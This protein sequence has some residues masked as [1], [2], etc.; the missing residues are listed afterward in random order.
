MAR[1]YSGKILKKK[2]P[3]NVSMQC[4]KPQFVLGSFNLDGSQFRR[5]TQ[6]SKRWWKQE[7][8]HLYFPSSNLPILTIDIDW[9]LVFLCNKDFFFKL[10]FFFNFS[11]SYKKLTPNAFTALFKVLQRDIFPLM[12]Q[13]VLYLRLSRI[14]FDVQNKSHSN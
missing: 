8:N 14:I 5:T 13:R 1:K 7:L 6:H 4:V 2:P 3:T 10:F 11:P 12:L 9:Q